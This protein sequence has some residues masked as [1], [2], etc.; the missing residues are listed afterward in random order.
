MICSLDSDG[1]IAV[2]RHSIPQRDSHFTVNLKDVKPWYKA[3]KV[4]VDEINAHA[5]QFKLK[6]GYKIENKSFLLRI[7]KMV[8]FTG[9]ILAFDNTRLVHGRLAYKDTDKSQ[10]F[11]I[12]IFLDWDEVYSKWRIIKKELGLYKE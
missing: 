12:G 6:P 10:R 9:D 11:L 8:A 5:A 4:F 7:K 3:M 1:N 2:V